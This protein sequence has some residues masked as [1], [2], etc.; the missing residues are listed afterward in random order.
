MVLRIIHS[1]FM[2]YKIYSCGLICTILLSYLKLW[3]PPPLHFSS[4]SPELQKG[5]ETLEEQCTQCRNQAASKIPSVLHNAFS[6]ESIP[7]SKLITI[8]FSFIRSCTCHCNYMVSPPQLCNLSNQ[9]HR[10]LLD[11]ELNH[12]HSHVLRSYCTVESQPQSG[13]GG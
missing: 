5:M 1:C 12:G 7:S 11:L 4:G 10:T 6:I 13:E 3:L 2:F 9:K 8:D